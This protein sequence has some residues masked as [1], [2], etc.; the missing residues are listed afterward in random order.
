MPTDCVRRFSTSKCNPVVV[1]AARV[2]VEGLDEFRRELKRLDLTDDLKDVN[3]AVAGFVVSKAQARAFSPL[4]RKA[5]QSLRASRTASRAQVLG[6]GAR[7]PFFGG[8]EFGAPSDQARVGPSGRRYLGHNQF[9]PWRGS[10]RQAG[11]FLYPAIR[12][13]EAQIVE[14]YGDAIERLAAKAFPD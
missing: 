14:M 1:K 6:G 3:L 7:A 11:Y 12:A 9:Q 13:N 2:N 8:A 10:T 5:A 4:E